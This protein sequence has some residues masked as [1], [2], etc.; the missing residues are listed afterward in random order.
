MCN[1]CTRCLS[2]GTLPLDRETSQ[3]P[4]ASCSLAPADAYEYLVVGSCNRPN[5]PGSQTTASCSC[6]AHLSLAVAV[7]DRDL[8]SRVLRV[9]RP[10]TPRYNTDLGERYSSTLGRVP[11]YLVTVARVALSSTEYQLSTN[12][13]G[14]HSPFECGV[15]WWERMDSGL[16]SDSTSAAPGHPVRRLS[17]TLQRGTAQARPM[18]SG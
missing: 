3:L 6:P 4:A 11:P 14:P 5:R 15:T 9:L 18:R 2:L 10:G 17:L 7:E 1:A 8:G 12:W 13:V 16:P